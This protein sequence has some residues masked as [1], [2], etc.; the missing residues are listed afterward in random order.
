MSEFF[1][2]VA[3]AALP[4]A[5]GLLVLT[6]AARGVLWAQLEGDERRLARQYLE[7]LATWCLIA[8]GTYAFAICASGEAGVLP[9][10]AAIAMAVAAIL[11]R[12][13]ETAAEP[14]PAAEQQRE[15]KAA[16]EQRREPKPDVRRSPVP[17]TLGPE[18]GGRRAFPEPVP[19]HGQTPEPTASASLWDEPQ[20]GQRTGLWAR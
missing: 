16:A 11:L 5:I 3:D 17:E 19:T 7:P 20:N 13:D 15:P 8:S 2:H 12:S 14:K 4:V 1:G 18:T 9:L 6:A 10:G